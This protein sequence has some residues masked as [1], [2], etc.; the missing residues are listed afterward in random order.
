MNHTRL[1]IKF[2]KILK[3]ILFYPAP[4]LFIFGFSGTLLL[5]GMGMDNTGYITLHF[6]SICTLVSISIAIIRKEIIF[7]KGITFVFSLF[8][9]T[10]LLSTILAVNKENSYEEL[11]L[12]IFAVISF[13]IT[14]SYKELLK[15]FIP[16]I[17][18]GFSI[19]FSFLYIFSFLIKNSL[20]QINNFS[21]YPFIV[22][23]PFNNHNHLGDFLVLTVILLF[24]NFYSKKDLSYWLLM[25]LLFLL[26]LASSSNPALL[27]LILTIFISVVRFVKKKGIIKIPTYTSVLYLPLVFLVLIM[28]LTKEFGNINGKTFSR[29]RGIYFSNTIDAVSEKPLFGFGLGNYIYSSFKYSRGDIVYTP[30]AKNIMLDMLTETGI[31]GT[32]LFLIIIFT[33]L[34]RGK[35]NIFYYLFFAILINFLSD[36]TYRISSFFILFFILAG[37]IYREKNRFKVNPLL[38]KIIQILL[39]LMIAVSILIRFSWP[40]LPN[41]YSLSFVSK[42]NRM[43][44]TSLIEKSPNK[45]QGYINLLLFVAHDDPSTD[46]ALASSYQFQGNNEKYLQFLKKAHVNAPFKDPDLGEKIYALTNK[47][48]GEKEAKEFALLYFYDYSRST[49]NLPSPTTIKINTFCQRIYKFSCPFRFQTTELH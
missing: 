15:R 41:F 7:P 14:F 42:L 33:L 19:A 18:F 21:G 10:L 9:T 40:Q 46:Y 1:S 38:L 4:Y 28:F 48:K 45:A 11:I 26:I 12:F 13:F 44:H 43:V 20:I 47:L 24:T 6:F 39:F 36:Y 32:L 37:I 25:V 16:I 2:N 17:I 31:I 27:M 35:K 3:E 22:S 49:Y 8:L 30:T 23:Q 29:E 34:L 5:E